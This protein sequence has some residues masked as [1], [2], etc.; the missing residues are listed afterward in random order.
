[1]Y[2]LREKGRLSIPTPCLITHYLLN[3]PGSAESDTPYVPL[4][5]LESL[6]DPRLVRV[7]NYE[8]GV[9][10]RHDAAK[11]LGPFVDAFIARWEAVQRVAVLPP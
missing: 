2:Y 5:R 4:G 1:M 10:G 6:E 7:G 3:D 9:T 8:E 11:I